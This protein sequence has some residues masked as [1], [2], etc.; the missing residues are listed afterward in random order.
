MHFHDVFLYRA[1]S[2][3]CLSYRRALGIEGIAQVSGGLLELILYRVALACPVD[4]VLG[5]SE[6]VLLALFPDQSP[7]FPDQSPARQAE[8]DERSVCPWSAGLVYYFP[9]S[10]S[11]G[12]PEITSLAR[13][14]GAW[15]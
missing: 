13:P 2:I 8:G 9:F 4:K 12:L 11:P 15:S 14:P 3:Q 6:A 1:S 7:V 5:E 10:Q